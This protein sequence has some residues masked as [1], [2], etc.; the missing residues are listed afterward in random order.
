MKLNRCRKNID[1]V[2][3]IVEESEEI[4]VKIDKVQEGKN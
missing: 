2:F 3:N 1:Q 4:K